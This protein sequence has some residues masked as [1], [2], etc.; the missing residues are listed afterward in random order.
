VTMTGTTR[1]E[2]ESTL[3]ESAT[4]CIRKQE[5]YP[6]GEVEVTPYGGRIHFQNEDD[7]EY[8]L[9]F[10]KTETDPDAGIDIL[11][12]AGGRV[13]VV[14]NKNDVFSYSFRD[15]GDSKVASGKGGGPIKN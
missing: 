3:P 8:R 13:T 6:P 2:E 10:W 14:I 12:P 7:N 15:I 9:R 5:L 11:L 4:I 1:A